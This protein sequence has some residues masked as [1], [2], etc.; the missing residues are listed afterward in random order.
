M[1]L[2]EYQAA[3]CRTNKDLG[4]SQ[5]V[6]LHMIIGMHSE[7]NELYDAIEK[8]DSV[9]ILEEL[10][11]VCWYL[12]NY[13][14]NIGLELWRVFEFDKNTYYYLPEKNDFDVQLEYA[15]SKLT[16][17]EKRAWVYNKETKREVYIEAIIETLKRL[18]DVCVYYNLDVEIGMG[19]NINKLKVRF[20]EKFREDQAN[21][22]TVDLER[23][24][25]EKNL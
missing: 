3:A 12:A 9:G 25:L 22:R 2:K 7:F 21:N 23:K 13:S 8:N 17:I 24:E 1:N 5:L 18:N 4:S 10:I 6:R 15:V 20:P 14:T 19:N 11:D 16:N